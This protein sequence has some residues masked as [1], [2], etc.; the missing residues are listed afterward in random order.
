M[1]KIALLSSLLMFVLFSFG[2][3]SLKG[4]K[5]AD[6]MI[7]M[8]TCYGVKN[9]EGYVFT[10]AE[11]GVLYTTIEYSEGSH[12]HGDAVEVD[13]DSHSHGDAVDMDEDSHSHGSGVN[14][15]SSSW[16]VEGDK[17]FVQSIETG[18]WDDLIVGFKS[19]T[20]WFK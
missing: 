10:F 20:C 9:A 11:N 2:Y 5:L 12:S 1:K 4:N 14:V 18:D 8:N 19:K 17:V 7:K 15:G 13:E 16:Y 6:A 3:A